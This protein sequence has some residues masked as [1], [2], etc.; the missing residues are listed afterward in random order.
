MSFRGQYPADV[1]QGLQFFFQV[2]NSH[3]MP[4]LRTDIASATVLVHHHT[5]SVVSMPARRARGFELCMQ[6]NPTSS[7]LL[8]THDISLN[9]K[10]DYR[11]NE[12]NAVD[13]PSVE[14]NP[15]EAMRMNKE[16]IS[17][18]TQTRRI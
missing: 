12:E 4:T 13:R 14:V 11:A 3:Q 5:I 9:T 10:C 7:I 18:R 17:K 16:T 2:A 8:I 1:D 6:T 15:K